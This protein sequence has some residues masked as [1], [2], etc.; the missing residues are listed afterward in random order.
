[1]TSAQD[2]PLSP[3]PKALMATNNTFSCDKSH[4]VLKYNFQQIVWIKTVWNSFTILGNLTLKLFQKE[5]LK[6]IV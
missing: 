2:R 6:H 4:N 5:K 1:M 3:G